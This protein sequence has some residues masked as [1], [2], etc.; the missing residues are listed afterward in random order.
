MKRR[1]LLNGIMWVLCCILLSG[2]GAIT[3]KL[4][5]AA[6]STSAT[7][8]DTVWD[9]T[10][11]RIS[12]AAALIRNNARKYKDIGE[13]AAAL[14]PYFESRYYIRQLR[15]MELENFCALY[16]SVSEFEKSCKFP[17][18]V[19]LDDLEAYLLYLESECPEILQY[20]GGSYNYYW[21][22]EE[23]KT[24][25]RVQITYA[26][27]Q[28]VYRKARAETEAV[29]DE[30]VSQ[31]SGLT[32]YE[33][34]MLVYRYI[35]ENCTYNMK[36]ENTFDAY[37]VL[38]KGEASC[39]GYSKAMLWAMQKMGVPCMCIG[40]EGKNPGQLGH[41]WN[42][43]EIDG[44]YYDLDVT[45]DDMDQEG[46]WSYGLV[47][48][49][50]CWQRDKYKIFDGY[51]R[52]SPPGAET[53]EA[54]YHAKNG[55]YFKS[56]GEMKKW[57]RFRL[58]ALYREGGGMAA[59]QVEDAQLYQKLGDNLSSYVDGWGYDREIPKWQYNWWT[60]EDS[61]T[62]LLSIKF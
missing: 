51:K 6:E 38:V 42:I 44:T 11:K 30:L 52:F 55:S 2:C 19:N 24:V 36:S 7:I 18:P 13:E 14:I 56:E 47:N 49:A 25:D 59:F 8:P 21:E 27:E 32:D 12:D 4:E 46:L 37:G 22:N 31:A 54:C 9:E 33:K 45:Q 40:G 34:E 3:M 50:A 57:L 58:D 16:R 29:L 23:R 53:M 17:Y 41:M 26:M 20:T 15:G 61:H 43:I 28:D 1:I 10:G 39:E 62:I 60:F 48:I 5:K 35:I